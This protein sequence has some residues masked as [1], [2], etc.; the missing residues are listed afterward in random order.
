M[1]QILQLKFNINEK[2]NTKKQ[3]HLQELTRL[4]MQQTKIFSQTKSDTQLFI[5]DLMK[6]LQEHHRQLE[7]AQLQEIQ[8]LA[9]EQLKA[10]VFAERDET[11]KD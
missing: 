8:K 11:K 2:L 5:Q 1:R 7:T 3:Q 10:V 4:L 9:E 6:D